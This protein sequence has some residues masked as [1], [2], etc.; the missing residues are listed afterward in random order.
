MVQIDDALDHSPKIEKWIEDI[1]LFLQK[2]Q[3]E[4]KKIF[5]RL[6]NS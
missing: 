4:A 5:R 6:M 1:Y 3:A 2:K